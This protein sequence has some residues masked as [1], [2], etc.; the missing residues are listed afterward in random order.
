M[1]LKITLNVIYIDVFKDIKK[2]IKN[3][4]IN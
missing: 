1:I 2:I 3:N 4:I